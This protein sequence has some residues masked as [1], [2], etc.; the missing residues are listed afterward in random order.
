MDCKKE[1]P[2]MKVGIV[3]IMKRIAGNFEKL[4]ISLQ[5][6]FFKI[7]SRGRPPSEDVRKHFK[8]VTEVDGRGRKT[9][10]QKCNYC[11]NEIIDLIDLLKDHLMKLNASKVLNVLKRLNHVLNRQNCFKPCFLPSLLLI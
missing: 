8:K 9:P 3:R 1:N 7:I 11:G 6:S 4:E 10:H 2:N 5:N